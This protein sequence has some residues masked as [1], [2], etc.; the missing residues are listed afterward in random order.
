MEDE[1]TW[2]KNLR[3]ERVLKFVNE[4][5]KRFR[6]FLGDLPEKLGGEVRKYYFL[7]NIRM[8]AITKRGVFLQINEA[9][10]QV[11]KL[12]DENKVI[13]DSK[14]LG[15]DV[16]LQGFTVDKEGKRLAYSF[17]I[18][19]ADEGITRVIDVDSGEIL[20]ELKPSV[21]N[22][23]WLEDGYYYARF[24]RKERTPDGVEAPAERIFLKKGDK[25]EMVFGKGLPQSY[26]ISMK[27]S[28]DEKYILT[29]VSFGWTKSDIYFGPLERPEEWKRVYESQFRAGPIDYVDGKL[30]I[31]TYDK[32]GMGRVIAIE[33][34]REEKEI[35]PEWEYPLEW[36]AVV[37]DKL[38]ASYLVDASSRLRIFTLN[39]EL[40]EETSF[41]VLG[42]LTLLDKSGDEALLKFE[43][44]TIPYRLY[45]FKGKLELLDEIKLEGDYEISEDFATSKDGTKIHYFLV[46]KKN[47]RSDKALVFGY[48]GFAIALTP[49][50]F[51]HVVPFLERGGTFVMPNLRGGSE[52]GEKWHRAGMRENKQNVFDDFIA[53]LEKL[54]HE[55]Y[56]VAAWGRSNGG[57]LVSAT[58]TQRP[59]V[60][61]AALIGYPVI[62][63]LRFHKLYIG[64]VWTTEYG[65]PDNP[66]DREFLLKYSP[67]HNVKSQKYP[68]TMIYTGLYDD[69]VHPAHAFKFAAKLKEV[70]APLYLRVE[71][72]S[73]HMGA[74]PETRVKEL[75]DLIAF[76]FKTLGVEL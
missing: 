46:K 19:G 74:S 72:K 75:T 5:N 59:D 45:R 38:L 23:I 1:F 34:G 51:P 64:K 25:H 67:Y 63:M 32:E 21:W 68:P 56:K 73:G 24:F 50:F 2:M 39:G 61:D 52:Y 48:G 66:K 29:T 53:V 14:E 8:G 41:D 71:T 9:D 57:L 69:R 76:V 17:S 70:N 26:F 10:R 13:V 35:I 62:D 18:G 49:R 37:G 22:I 47:M 58:L 54:K 33:D 20:E 44:F 6:E 7:P 3:D 30:Y 11:I 28:S 42:T 16:L 40:L 31:L 43:T 65:D 27:K 60:M 4:E 55:G 15:E 36:A 12:L